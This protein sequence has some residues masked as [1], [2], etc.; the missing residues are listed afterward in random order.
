[1]DLDNDFRGEGSAGLWQATGEGCWYFTRRVRAHL[2]ERV[3]E[4]RKL[5]G[6]GRAKVGLM[7]LV[8]V[9]NGRMKGVVFQRQNS[10]GKR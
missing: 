2:V 1:M 5:A 9:R 3:V 6:R 8:A 7:E 4:W 10:G